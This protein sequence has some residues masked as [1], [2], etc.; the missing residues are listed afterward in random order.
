LLDDISMGTEC[1][2][3]AWKVSAA[4]LTEI[5][6]IARNVGADVQLVAIPSTVQLDRSQFDV[7]RRSTLQVD[8]RLLESTRP[9]QPLNELCARHDVPS[10]DLLPSFERH[11]DP[12]S[13][14]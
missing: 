13:L 5:F 1:N 11:P 2:A 14:Y 10:L 4:F 3:A 9:Q 12:A 8:D 6:A 7:Y